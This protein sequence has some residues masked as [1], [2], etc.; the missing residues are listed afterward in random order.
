MMYRFVLATLLFSL[1]AYT[2]DLIVYL[3]TDDQ[4]LLGTDLRENEQ[5]NKF[6]TFGKCM[7]TLPNAVRHLLPTKEYAAA[8]RVCL[9]ACS[10]LQGRQS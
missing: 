6:T 4:T 10:G 1:Q 3:T 5:D 9:Q 7:G 8:A 2:V